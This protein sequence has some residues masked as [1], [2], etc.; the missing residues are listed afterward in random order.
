MIMIVFNL[1]DL[2]IFGET[3]Q[4]IDGLFSGFQAFHF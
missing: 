1:Y 2:K 4:K 3:E